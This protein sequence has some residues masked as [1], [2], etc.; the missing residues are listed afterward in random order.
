MGS[1]E[2]EQTN[3]H[4]PQ[5]QPHLSSLVVRPSESGGCSDYE[6]GELRRD[7]PPPYSRSDRF[8]DNPAFSVARCKNLG[9][10]EDRYCLGMDIKDFPNTLSLNQF[11]DWIVDCLSWTSLVCFSGYG[12][13]AGSGSPLR[14]RKVVV[15]RYSPD[16]DHSG[17]P[18]RS[19]GFWGGRGPGRFRDSIPPYGRGRGGGRS[20]GRGFDRPRFSPEPFRGEGMDRNNSNV[21]PRD[22]DWICPDPLCRNLNFARRE[23][24]NKC[25]TFRFAPG[26]TPRG[27]YPPSP[28]LHAP[29]PRFSGPPMER[30]PDRSMNG[31]RPPP[32]GW[33]RVSPREFEGGPPPPRHGGRS[34]DHYMQRERLDYDEEEDY[35]GRNKFDRRGRES[36]FFFHERRG[37]EGRNER[38]P[39]SSPPPPPRGRWSHDV[40]DRS[41]SPMM[42]RPLSKDYCW[43]SYMDREQDHDAEERSQSPMRGGPPPKDYHRDSYMDKGRDN[44]R[45]MTRHRIGDPY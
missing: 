40:R 11:L 30:S 21:P 7:P 38:G 35:I 43:D 32:R 1:R 22:G 19:R 4:Q 20:S 10:E 28:P 23:Y 37:Y 6:P 34:P 45:V 13:H 42:G 36:C 12:M 41:L 31:Y 25:D 16:F 44:R 18:P 17:L 26:E 5:P 27:N 2:R 14:H 39:P 8:S 9:I 24:C 33:G 29:L 3:A 15:H